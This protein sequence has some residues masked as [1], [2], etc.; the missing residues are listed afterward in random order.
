MS[1]QSHNSHLA[2]EMGHKLASAGVNIVP[3]KLD[4]VGAFVHHEMTDVMGHFYPSDTPF[5]SGGGK[6][7]IHE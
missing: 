7:M 1:G 2:S 6:G 4:W 5:I 3:C